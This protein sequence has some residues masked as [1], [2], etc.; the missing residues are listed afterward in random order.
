MS[1]VSC[2]H[3]GGCVNAS[4][5]AGYATC[6]PEQDDIV[7]RVLPSGVEVNLL[8]PDP[9][10][11]HLVDIANSL[12]RQCRY[13]GHVYGFLSVAEHSMRVARILRGQGHTDLVVATGLLHD[14]SEAYL[15]DMI[16]PLKHLPQLSLFREIE[17]RFELA[18]AQRFGLLYPTPSEVKEADGIDG[19]AERSPSGYRRTSM[20]L[21]PN[22][23]GQ[24][25]RFLGMARDL[26][27]S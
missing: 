9:S 2:D 1:L 24:V 18:I 20:G 8:D 17:G 4:Y 13:N 16:G 14:A 26:G 12:A 19:R 5:C 10:S 6:M 22:F 15:G 7:S 27:L 23:E 25:E 11:I 3:P 21:Q